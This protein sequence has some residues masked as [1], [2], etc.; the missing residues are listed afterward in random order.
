MEILPLILAL[1]T[2]VFLLYVLAG[3]LGILFRRLL[4]RPL[5]PHSRDEVGYLDGIYFGTQF[6][7]YLFV[8]HVLGALG[9]VLYYA[10]ISPLLGEQA[11]WMFILN[12]GVANGV[13]FLG[14]V[15]GPGISL[16]GCF[17]HAGRLW[18][19]EPSEAGS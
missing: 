2:G 1:L 9:G 19:R 4:R 7:K 11:D 16:V 12:K 14:W 18:K 6:L 15:W 17:I 3:G 13:F 5:R 10:A 8:A